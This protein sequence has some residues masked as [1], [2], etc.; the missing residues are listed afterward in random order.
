MG[1]PVL[2]IAEGM[3][4]KKHNNMKI[5]VGSVVKAKAGE[6][7]EKKREGR[8]RR[9]RKLVM[10]CVHAVV[11]KKRFVISIQRWAEET[12][13]FLFACVFKF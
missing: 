8:S 6:M 13:D 9:M 1:S 3:K 11:G 5:R 7:E 12:D 10:G 4:E 2:T